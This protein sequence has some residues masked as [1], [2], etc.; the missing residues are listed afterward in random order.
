MFKPSLVMKLIVVV[1]FVSLVGGTVVAPVAKAQ[2][3]GA[4]GAGQPL[5][6]STVPM[7]VFPKGT[8]PISNIAYIWTTVSGAVN[9]QIQVMKG[10][11]IILEYFYDSTNCSSGTCVARSGGKLSNST[12]SW[13]MRAY[14]GGA[15]KALSA[16]Q[17]FVVSVPPLPVV[18]FNSSFN[19]DHAGWSILKG[20]WNHESSAYFTTLGVLGKASTIAHQTNY[21]TLTY[22]VRMKRTGSDSCANA[23]LIRGDAVQD[24]GG[25]WNKEYTFNYTNS[26]G[27]GSPLFII[28]KDNN[29]V[30]T[31]LKDWTT[32]GAV[33]PGDWNTLKV[34]ATGSLLKFY[35]NNILVWSGNDSTFSSGHVGIGMYRSAGGTCNNK[36]LVDWAKLTTSV[37]SSADAAA[38]TVKTLEA[39]QKEVGGDNRNMAP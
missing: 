8:V 21:A 36:L 5:M 37:T 33:F 9:Y 30:Y 29:G 25:W 12:Y 27:Y 10:S 7:L 16:W 28:T 4:L 23:I 26:S 32:T 18:G 39:N 13:R 6:T 19:S 1:V 22:E 11:T 15:W 24:S 34:T 3:E 17:V 20:T 38:D 35:I 2:S 14:V 31:K